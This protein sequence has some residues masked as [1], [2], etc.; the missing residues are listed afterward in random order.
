MLEIA[1][2]VAIL[3]FSN[4]DS[5]VIYITD[6]RAFREAFSTAILKPANAKTCRFGP[7]PNPIPILIPS[8]VVI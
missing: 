3:N 2:P 8:E 4:V 5:S 1:I 6:K 7:M